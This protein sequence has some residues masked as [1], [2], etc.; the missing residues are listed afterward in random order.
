MPIS[1]PPPWD[2]PGL[3]RDVASGRLFAL[4]AD[5]DRVRDGRVWDWLPLVPTAALMRWVSEDGA[6]LLRFT[7][8]SS[9]PF[10]R[11]LIC[12]LL[13]RH[14]RSLA[15]RRRPVSLIEFCRQLPVPAAGELA[16]L[17]E[18]AD[19]PASFSHPRILDQEADFA[20]RLWRVAEQVR[21]VHPWAADAIRRVAVGRTPDAVEADGPCVRVVFAST[22]GGLRPGAVVRF[23]LLAER[24][25]GEFICAPAAFDATFV[26][27]V[28]GVA[29]RLGGRF[30]VLE[31]NWDFLTDGSLTDTSGYLALL[32]AQ[33]LA[34]DPTPRAS[35]CWGLPAWLVITGS[36]G[37]DGGVVPA[38]Y[39]P[40]KCEQ[41]LEEGV[42]VLMVVDDGAPC[43]MRQARAEGVTAPGADDLWILRCRDVE[44]V[45]A[46]VRDRA[47]RWPVRAPAPARP[48]APVDPNR[49]RVR[50]LKRFPVRDYVP[51]GFAVEQIHRELERLDRRGY[52]HVRAP[53]AW[54]KTAL[55][56]YLKENPDA[57]R[58]FGRVVRYRAQHGMYEK[59]VL[60]VDQVRRQC[61]QLVDEDTILP[62]FNL[63]QETRVEAARER[64][65]ELL[66]QTML[67]IGLG[68][69]VL[70]VD[71]LD[72]L[73]E[74]SEG[75]PGLLSVLPGPEVLA[76]G[77]FVLLLSRPDLRP[78][79]ARELDRLR[80]DP[81]RFGALD[82]RS[83]TPEYQALT[84]EYIGRAL[85]AKS[86]E[87]VLRHTP[88]LQ[89][90]SGGNFL[91]LRLLCRLFA[92]Q[93]LESLAPGR[94][95]DFGRAISDYLDHVAV[96]VQGGAE[97]FRR[98][99]RPVLL[100]T[101][102]AGTASRADLRR[103][104]GLPR[105]L[106]TDDTLDRVLDELVEFGLLAAVDHSALPDD[107]LFSTSHEE[108]A[109]WY[110]ATDHPEW[111]GALATFPTD[112]DRFPPVATYPG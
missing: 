23:V 54:G 48:F 98:W 12:H 78:A 62:V 69:L 84:G 109:D 93:D 85:H 46:Q 36:P 28:E 80:A 25:G 49:P 90:R 67:A 7:L 101:A 77:C 73:T 31:H 108:L 110:R 63:D 10:Y 106:T 6:E 33:T 13:E 14:L 2:L 55:A 24:E 44:D 27:S 89:E 57:G 99:H 30:R 86:R 15:V 16:E 111:A 53:A 17:W 61:E 32:V 64:L 94:R 37:R 4:L 50:A 26:K 58:W 34:A 52:L 1:P 74:P 112:A 68:R 20:A 22:G 70:A 97:E 45:V 91:H 21:A 35:Q 102:A 105:D 59:P 8:R 65:A 47:W 60:L 51:P 5:L 76:D 71:G 82:L 39:L 79:T 104:L 83:D 29:N 92:G 41:L 75:T 103:R 38:G 81:T 42:R 72:E 95:P 3:D 19:L 66:R 18:L 88:T 87:V 9:D 56:A 11:P 96:Q 40:R 107:T 43:G 100:A